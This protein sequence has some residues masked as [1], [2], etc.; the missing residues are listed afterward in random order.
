MPVNPSVIV[1]D[2]VPLLLQHVKNLSARI[3][4][5]LQVAGVVMNRTRYADR[6]TAHEEALWTQLL[7]AG[8][9]QLGVPLHGFKAQVPTTTEIRNSEAEKFQPPPR[10]SE[11]YKAFR[12]LAT[13][14]EEPVAA[15]MPPRGADVGFHRGGV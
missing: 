10:G 4:P 7:V 8:Q 5:H 3:N 13:E 12:K 11:L 1:T 9:D 15:R 6:L 2:R 14:L